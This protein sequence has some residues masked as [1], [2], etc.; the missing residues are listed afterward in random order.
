MTDKIIVLRLNKLTTVF[1]F[2]LILPLIRTLL[3]LSI[4]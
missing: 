2:L 1:I 3:L 4:D